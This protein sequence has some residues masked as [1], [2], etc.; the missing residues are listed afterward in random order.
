[1]LI[2]Y[3]GYKDRLAKFDYAGQI[4][5]RTAKNEWDFK[6]IKDYAV[7][8]AVHYAN[9][10]LHYT[11]YTDIIA[12]GITGW[13]NDYGILEH[14]IGVYYVS[15]SNFGAG[16]KIAEYT[17]LSFLRSE[18]FDAFIKQVKGFRILLRGVYKMG[19]PAKAGKNRKSG[20]AFAGITPISGYELG[21]WCRKSLR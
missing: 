19:K 18:N 1:M 4:A 5:N 12:I 8:G 11:D 7:N 20:F 14:E 21:L 16:Q 2:E 3:N 17:D 10:L 15:K 9:A 6:A 13:K